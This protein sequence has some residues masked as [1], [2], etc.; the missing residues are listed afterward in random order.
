MIAIPIFYD[1]ILNAL[2]EIDDNII[3]VVD[4]YIVGELYW[5]PRYGIGAIIQ[6]EKMRFNTTAILLGHY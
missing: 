6:M 4:V 5:Q 3:E 1:V 2:V